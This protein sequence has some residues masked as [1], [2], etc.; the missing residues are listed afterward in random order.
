MNRYDSDRLAD[1]LV[2]NGWQ[3]TNDE[4]KA[5]LFIVI[6]CAVRKKASEKLFSEL[7][8][9]RFFKQLRP[10]T[11]IAMGGCVAMEA[12]KEV[13]RRA[14]YVDIVFGTQTSHRLIDLIA[15]A[16]RGEK[17]L[18]DLELPHL[19][20]F[21]YLPK[22]QALGASAFISIMEGCNNFCSYCIVPYTRGREESRSMASI[23]EEAKVLIDKGVKEINLLGQNVNAYLDSISGAKLSDLIK[24]LARF[25]DLARIRF[26]TSHPAHMDDA[27]VAVYSAEPKLVS[28]L[29]LPVQSGSDRVLKRMNRHYTRAQYLALVAKLKAARPDL[30]LATDIIVGFPGETDEDFD[31]TLSLVKAV[32]FDTSFSFIYSPRPHTPAARWLDQVPIEVRRERL[33]ILQQQLNS[34]AASYSRAMVG[35]VQPILV[36]GLSSKTKENAG[37]LVQLTGK[38]INNRTVNFEAKR[39]VIGQLVSVKITEALPNSLRGELA[40]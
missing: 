12:G 9:L 17:K 26:T 10:Q 39:D 38:S 32:N 19:E 20:K 8:R 33:K 14:P 30:S 24:E 37:D 1:L 3:A 5:D 23:L 31:D 15:R 4:T 34:Q 7:G 27:M 21:K 36:T 28:H 22:P 29:H 13:F 35:T 18:I 2:E 16:K 25:K 6:S 11:L 40:L